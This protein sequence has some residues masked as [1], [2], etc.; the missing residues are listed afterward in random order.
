[1]KYPYILPR[2]M[3]AVKWV[4]SAEHRFWPKVRKTRSCWWYTDSGGRYEFFTIKGRIF[5]ANRVSYMLAF[6]EIPDGMCVCHTCDHPRCV[7]PKHL[8]LGT[9]ED[10]VRD[11]DQ[12]GRTARGDNAGPR[13]HP[14]RYP[15]GDLHWMRL[16]PE[17]LTGVLARLRSFSHKGEFNGRAVVTE[18]LVREIRRVGRNMSML[19]LGKRYGIS[20][21]QACSILNYKS[22]KHVQ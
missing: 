5:R 10:N 21:S 12:K 17:K 19:S 2:G 22:W 6:G 15:K 13:K 20:A 7:N 11:R 1:M 18:E 4:K 3:E 8:W 9:Y 14:D 16:H